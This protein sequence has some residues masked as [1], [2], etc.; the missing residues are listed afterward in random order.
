MTSMQSYIEPSLEALDLT[1]EKMDAILA[2]AKS[3]NS[4]YVNNSPFP[5]IVIDNFFPDSL[6][7]AISKEI[8]ELKSHENEKNFHGSMKKFSSRD[9][10]SMGPMTRR[11]LTDLN[12][13]QFCKFIEELTSISN[14]I[15]DPHFEGGGIHET[16]SGGFLKIHADFNYSKPLQLDRRVN[17]LIYLNEDWQEDWDGRLELWDKEMKEKVVEVLPVFNRMVLFS[18]DDFSFHG[19]PEPTKCPDDHTRKSLALYYYS[20]GRPEAETS[21][22]RTE[23]DYRARPDEKL[24]KKTKPLRKMVKKVERLFKKKKD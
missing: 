9:L 7:Q 22:K 2:Y 14:I 1:E 6:L 4:E 15:P 24:K 3:K 23:T 21:E 20:N 18:T 12:S 10:C 11:I 16:S 5:H 8:S 19:Q 17:L 13:S